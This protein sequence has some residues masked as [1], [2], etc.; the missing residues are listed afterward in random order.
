MAVT[1]EGLRIIFVFHLLV[2]Y[3]FVPTAIFMEVIREQMG[4]KRWEN[5]KLDQC[6]FLRI[7]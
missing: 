6:Q 7:W 5:D 3:K 1:R 2:R 4:E